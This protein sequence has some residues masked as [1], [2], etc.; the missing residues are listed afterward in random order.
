M[1]KIFLGTVAVLAM[2]TAVVV[3]VA[4]RLGR[5]PDATGELSELILDA[6][7]A[8]WAERFEADEEAI[9]R[10]VTESGTDDESLR[11]RITEEIGVVDVKLAGGPRSG[12]AIAASVI[13]DYPRRG[14][15][16]T[17]EFSLAWLETPADVREEMLRSGRSEVFRKWS[18]ADAVVR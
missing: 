17:A 4:G 11:A 16:A 10:A 3:A 12:E 14:E 5:R 2:A 7:A 6:F 13:C 1:L 9:R 18:L 8:D 15:R